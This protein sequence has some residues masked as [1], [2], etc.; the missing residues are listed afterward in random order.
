MKDDSAFEKVAQKY[1]ISKDEV[2]REIEKSIK[3]AIND[4]LYKE[5]WDKIKNGKQSVSAF[6]LLEY[7][8]NKIKNDLR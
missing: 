3:I 4:P 5:K 6:E 7:I 1:N 8:T 2:I